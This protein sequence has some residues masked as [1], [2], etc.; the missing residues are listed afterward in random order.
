MKRILTLLAAVFLGSAGFVSGAAGIN[1]ALQKGLFEEEA[2][3]NL[4]A[5]IQAYQSVI[6]Q[7]D[8]QRKFAATAIFRLGEC[9]RK[10]GKTN[11]ATAQY[12]R[13][14]QEFADQPALATLSQQNLSGLGARAPIG[15]KPSEPI[16]ATRPKP[17]KFNESRC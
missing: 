9:Y 12:Q 13:I 8:D 15:T 5:A 17:R 14:V 3:H 10:Q 7:F 2:N 11:E 6:K 4:E 1:E 16:P